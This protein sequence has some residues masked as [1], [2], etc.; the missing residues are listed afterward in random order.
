MV[1]M[2]TNA[3]TAV[4]YLVLIA[5]SQLASFTPASAEEPLRSNSASETATVFLVDDQTGEELAQKHGIR[6]IA[7]ED[8]DVLI[9]GVVNGHTPV[10]LFHQ[11]VDEDAADNATAQMEFRPYAGEKPV[12]KVAINLPLPQLIEANK[13]YA[14][15]RTAWQKG[16]RDYQ[17]RLAGEVEGFIRQVTETQGSV[18]ERFDKMLVAEPRLMRRCDLRV[19]VNHGLHQPTVGCDVAD[20]HPIRG[21]SFD[22]PWIIRVVEFRDQLDARRHGDPRDGVL[23]F[24]LACQ[25][26]GVAPHVE[27]PPGRSRFKSLDERANGCAR[28]LAYSKCAVGFAFVRHGNVLPKT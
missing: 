24:N 9:N 17:L 2:N 25:M 1:F 22:G 21:D 18:S 28:T 5:A 3:M 7:I 14:A 10:R 20:F 23:T 26:F 4:K 16:V 6:P 15:K 12:K 19:V 13:A 27:T 11:A 8:L